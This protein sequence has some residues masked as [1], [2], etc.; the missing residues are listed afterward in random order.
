MI[1]SYD[2]VAFAISET[3]LVP[4]SRFRV[5]GYSCLRDDRGDGYAGAALLIKSSVTFTRLS[6]PPFPTSINAVAAKIRD[7]S[8]LSIYIS[9]SHAVHISDL[10]P[11]LSS[12]SGSF[13]ILGDFNCHHLMWGSADYDILACDLVDLMEDKNICLLNDGSPTRRTAPGKNASAVDLSLCSPNF[14]TLLSWS[15]L[16][17]SYG[18]DHLPILISCPTSFTQPKSQ[19]SS[20]SY[21]L[22]KADWEQFAKDC[23]AFV[24]KFPVLSQ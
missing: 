1:A 19:L 6:L 15:V 13:L 11:I 17:D 8:V 22:S 21:L 16:H 4:G 7:I 23:D 24:N 3:W 20:R 14:G 2:P 18:S 10:E 5:S 12:L 9:D